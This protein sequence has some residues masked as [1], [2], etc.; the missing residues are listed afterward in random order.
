MWRLATCEMV[1][2]RLIIQEMM[3]QDHPT[4]N[5]CVLLGKDVN[6]MSKYI[7]H[8]M[9]LMTDP[10]DCLLNTAREIWMMRHQ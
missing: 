5:I 10:I 6:K 9:N 4:K 2:H 3:S 8:L 7:T 1:G